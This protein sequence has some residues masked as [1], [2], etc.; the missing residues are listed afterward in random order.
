MRLRPAVLLACSLALVPTVA[1]AQAVPAPQ[2]EAEQHGDEG[3]PDRAGTVHPWTMPPLRVQGEPKPVLREEDHIGT[4]GQ[5]RWTANRRFPTT[6]IYVAPAGKATMEVW[7]RYNAPTA[8]LAGRRRIQSFIEAEF[9]LGHHLQLDLYVITEQQ[10]YR[11]AIGVKKEKAELRWALADWGRLWGNPTVYLEWTRESGGPDAIEGK[12]LLG[13]ELAPGLHAGANLAFEQEVGGP[14]YGHEYQA[15]VGL[16]RTLVDEALS[17]GFEGRVE[18]HD[19]R[20]ARFTFHDTAYLLGPSLAWSPI[21]P[22]HVMWALLGGTGRATPG[23]SYEGALE[24][25]FI[26]GWTF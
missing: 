9:G 26:G 13:G 10:D 14:G 16:S 12:L 2:H 4:Y 22:A 17:L 18:L 6:R 21:G 15:T 23:G 7:Q 20:G 11:G 25:W 5:P 3:Q 8:D 24:S 19:S 1:L